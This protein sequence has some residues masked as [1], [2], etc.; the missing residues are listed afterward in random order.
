MTWQRDRRCNHAKAQFY[1][2]KYRITQWRHQLFRDLFSDRDHVG[3][4]SFRDSIGFNMSLN[5]WTSH[6]KQMTMSTSVEA[7]RGKMCK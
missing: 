1:Q 6:T 5:R 2:N 3:V 4:H 7:E